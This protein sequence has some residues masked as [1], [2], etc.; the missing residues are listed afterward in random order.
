MKHYTEEFTA[1]TTMSEAAKMDRKKV[2]KTKL[3][4]D[5]KYRLRVNTAYFTFTSEIKRDNFINRYKDQIIK[6]E[7]VNGL[8]KHEFEIIK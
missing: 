3:P 6:F 8:K 4:K 2:K 7:G 1:Q 5:G